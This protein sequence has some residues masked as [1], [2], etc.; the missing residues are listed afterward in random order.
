MPS[1]YWRYHVCVSEVKQS[2]QVVAVCTDGRRIFTRADDA[3]R[4]VHSPDPYSKF[5][6]TGNT[7]HTVNRAVRQL[8]VDSLRY[9]VREMHV[10]GFRFDLAS[11]FSRASDGSIRTSDAPIFGQI[12]ADPELAN[13]RLIAE[14]WDA[15]GLQ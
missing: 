9:W 8:I 2:P 4:G 11:I 6:G 7:L 15:S 1:D 14:P 10:D 3:G 12:A 5:S 13:V